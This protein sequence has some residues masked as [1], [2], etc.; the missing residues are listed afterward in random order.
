MI[1]PITFDKCVID[2]N[3]DLVWNEFV[4]SGRKIPL[5]TVRQKI[6]DNNKDFYRF[7]TDEEVETLTIHEITDYLKSINEYDG[8]IDESALREKYKM[9][10]RTRHLVMWHDGSTICNG[11]HVL[12]LCHEVYD[13]AVHLTDEEELYKFKKNIDVQWHC[14][15][16]C[17]VYVC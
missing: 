12:F 11:P 1:V 6:Y 9:L 15:T 13:A 5:T 4:V 17:R 3:G 10:Q 7:K 2:N 8:S 14:G 16:T